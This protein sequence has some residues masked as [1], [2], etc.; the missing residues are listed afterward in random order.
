ML[1]LDFYHGLHKSYVVSEEEESIENGVLN[2]FDVLGLESHTQ[3]F[4]GKG[5]ME[6]RTSFYGSFFNISL[7]SW[8]IP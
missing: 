7:F 2:T 5:R 6:E 3:I 4:D 8:W 1:E